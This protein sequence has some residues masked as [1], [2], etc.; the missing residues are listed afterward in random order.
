MRDYTMSAGERREW[1]RLTLLKKRHRLR[2]L[3]SVE[4]VAFSQ[5]RKRHG[6]K[7]KRLRLTDYRANDAIVT[8]VVEI[9]GP[10]W[11]DLWKSADY[12]VGK[13]T[14]N[15]RDYFIEGFRKDGPIVDLQIGT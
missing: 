4:G 1:D 3:W 9:T 14:Q 10:T 6:V 8:C 2:T 15:W 12:L 7:A 5:M 11:L 13:T